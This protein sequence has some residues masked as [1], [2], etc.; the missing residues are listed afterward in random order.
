MFSFTTIASLLL[1]HWVADFVCQPDEVAKKKATSIK[2]LHM[3]KKFSYV[4]KVKI[5]KYVK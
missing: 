1:W 5:I 4:C 2:Y 3:S